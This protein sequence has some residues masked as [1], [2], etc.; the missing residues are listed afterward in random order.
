[1]GF[2]TPAFL[3]GLAALAVPVLIHLIHRERREVVAFPSLMFL[4]RIPYKS[5]RRQKLRNLLLF[6]LRCAA[7]I[8]LVAA[9]ARPL[10]ERGGAR[11]AGAG[12][13]GREVVILVDRSYSMGYGTRWQRALDAARRAVDNVLP[14]D[15]ATVVFFADAA[16]AANR[17]TA[18]RAA[19]RATVDAGT[20]GS[21]VT[22]YAPALKLASGIL[23]ASELPRR[24][25]VLITDFQ[26]VGWDGHD[27]VRLPR[28]TTVT[29]VSVGEEGATSNI[30]ATSMDLHRD[31]PA[32]REHVTA[33]VRLTNKGAAPV[34]GLPVAIEVNGRTLQ[35]KPVTL[36]ANSSATVAFAPFPLGDGLSRGTVHAG[37]DVLPHDNLFHFTLTRGQALA[38]LIVEPADAAATRSLYL[39]R[40]LAL[41]D[42][43]PMRAQVKK[44]GQLRAADLAGQALVIL[45][46][47][48]LPGG[49]TG[50][51]LAAFVRGGGG[52]LVALGDRSSAASW[53]SGR[54]ALLPGPVGSP[55][56][57]SANWGGTLGLIDR[58]HPVF[59]LFRA[60]R[61]GDFSA[62]RFFRYRPVTLGPGD[63]VLARYDDGGPALIERRVGAGKVLIWT[64]TLDAFWNDLALQP[65]FLP[66]VHQLAK[67]TAGYAE[68]APWFT[69][70]Q[71]VDVSGTMATTATASAP[72]SSAV[73]ARAAPPAAAPGAPGA[74]PAARAPSSEEW[75]AV[76][77]SGERTR[78][79]GRSAAR[80]L[81]LAE[82]GFYELRRSD[83]DGHPSRVVAVNLDLAESDLSTMDPQELIGAVTA[84]ADSA[85]AAG[86]DAELTVE[87]RERRQ[88]IWW[89]L[90]AAAL[91]LL[92][93]ETAFSN[94]L[95]GVRRA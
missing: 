48:G 81:V 91:L 77:P 22:R 11:A 50:E 55:V 45:N 92:A 87:E 10:F 62:A 32:G 37:Q 57:R 49:D 78:L 63:A 7:L 88:A 13:R 1:M 95:S 25:V 83:E 29:P 15:R 36:A 52:L 58:S 80:T 34:S 14:D 41:G 4:R 51:R 46:D 73:G 44:A 3:I 59:E 18:D 74:A 65:V 82:Q 20:V 53:E 89:Y 56:D 6:L 67:Y 17:A 24:E 33:T 26:R 54:A 75:N 5:V 12:A 23:D 30:S 86:P 31:Y 70:G 93:A 9:F 35:T 90:L 72:D 43:P 27:A 21:G 85:T 76:A 38:V 60:P 28:G 68:D 69:V 61:S 19:L 71:A 39:T 2:L 40:A 42:R 47:A 16:S 66:F 8:L 94:R 84:R 64:S 79:G